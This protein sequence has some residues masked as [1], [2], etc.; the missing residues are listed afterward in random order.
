[1]KQIKKEVRILETHLDN[2]I[3]A[4]QNTKDWDTASSLHVR[5]SQ[6]ESRLAYLSTFIFN[7]YED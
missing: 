4:L 7:S 5:I 1:M 2:A 6:L 3:I